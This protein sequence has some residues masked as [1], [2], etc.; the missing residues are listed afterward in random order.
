MFAVQKSF[1]SKIL[2]LNALDKFWTK[3]PLKQLCKSLNSLEKHVAIA[4]VC[5]R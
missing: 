3:L 5:M 2:V 4:Y 1:L